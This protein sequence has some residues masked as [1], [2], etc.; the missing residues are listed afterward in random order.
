MKL[1]P[2]VTALLAT[3]LL[4]GCTSDKPADSTSN[5]PSGPSADLKPA[6]KELKVGVV[7][8][9]GGRG[10]KSFNDSAW[11]GI[12]KA[13]REFN[14]TV[15][16]VDSKAAKDYEANLSGLAD[17]GMDLIFAVGITQQDA[18]KAVAPRYPNV[19]FAIIDGEVDGPNVRNLK[20]KEE[21]G[22]FLAGYLAGLM[23]K[24]NKIGF[25]GGMN[26]PLI[27]KFQ[28]GYIA[29]AKAANPAV[30]ALPGKFTESWDDVT[31][32]EAAARTLL[33]GG[34]DIVY[35]AAGRAGI[36]VINAA[37]DA[38]KYVIGVDSDQDYL[39][40]G[41]VLTSMVKRVDVSVYETIKDL[42]AGTFSTGTK[43][44]T[45]ADNGVGL[46]EMKFTKDLIG[47]DKLAKV[48]EEKKKLLEGSVAVPTRMSEVK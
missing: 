15:A 12:E 43:E 8:D 25:V 29:G 31:L 13:Q 48:E 39:K 22:S 7:F 6:G 32:G 40:P 10:D 1:A 20:F 37:A 34:A 3:A 36:G 4:A 45:L 11:A 14:L 5:V 2:I 44:Y 26:I 28:A 19:K 18:L 9:S 30:V 27:E 38:K 46:S 24:T 47:A 41:F 42:N 23:T 35:A 16:T 33:D 21:Q 17:K